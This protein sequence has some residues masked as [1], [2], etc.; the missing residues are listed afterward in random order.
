MGLAVW[1]MTSPATH[2]YT[3]S[4]ITWSELGCGA[5]LFICA[6]MSLSW[7]LGAVRWIEAAIG[8]YLMS[9]PLLFWAAD[10]VAYL[11]CTLTGA[12]VFGFAVCVQ[13]PPGVAPL[14]AVDGPVVP[15][16][17]TF[18]PSD[19]TQRVP[20]IALAF[21]GLVISRYLAA[22]QLEHIDAI[23]DPFFAGTRATLNG[24]EDIITSDVSKAW[25]VPDAGLGAMTYMLE[26][27]TGLIG[28][29]RRWRTMP[30][31]V[32]LFGIMIVPLG[33]VSI[34]FIV[35]QPIL[36]GTWCT[37]CLVA[38]AAMLIQIPYSLDELVATAQFLIRRKR[39]G[40]SLLRVFFVGDTDDDTARAHESTDEFD[41]GPRAIVADC[42]GGGVNVP[43]NLAVCI[44][45]GVFLMCTRL[46]LGAEPPMAHADH[47]IGALVLAISVTALAEVAR[48]V[49]F[50]NMLLGAC[51]VGAPWLF[52]AGF[53]A[54]LIIDT[55]LGL[56]LILLCLPRGRIGN[57]YGDI[58]PD[59]V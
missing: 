6:L 46:V 20:I 38:A 39:A 7:K 27:L 11:N 1:L 52:G 48:P 41:R 40:R 2:G 25:P 18:S 53:G 10:P 16:G 43:W 9:A 51:L 28:S 50:L 13:P 35:I 23:W 54:S 59:L 45:I 32:M 12:L 44:V 49:R 3:Q 34:F 47:L 4:A 15:P 42:L 8:I 24:T 5:V 56:A 58:T 29:S 19:W 22:Y 37:L 17:W 57:R 30:W 21:I 14:A 33:A 55:V 26:I 36:I 31:L